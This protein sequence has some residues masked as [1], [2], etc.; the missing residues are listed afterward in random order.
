MPKYEFV[1]IKEEKEIIEHEKLL[2]DA[3]IMRSPDEWISNHYEKIDNYRLRAPYPYTDLI[4]LG[5]KKDNILVATLVINLNTKNKMQFEE[6]GF[7]RDKI[8]IKSNF[9]EGIT[10]CTSGK[11]FTIDDWAA[12][13]DGMKFFIIEFKKHNL[14]KIYGTC[15]ERLKIFYL[16]LGFII[17]DKKDSVLLLELTV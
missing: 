2:Y 17:I 9:A 12:F 8:D 14:Q 6:E 7:N 3:F 15:V 1:E 16:K 13:E 4:V 10:F 5:V 11:N